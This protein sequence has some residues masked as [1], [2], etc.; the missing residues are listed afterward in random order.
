MKPI[1]LAR[2]LLTHPC[3]TLALR[4]YIGGLFIYASMYKINYTGEFAET[5]ANYQVVPY[6]GVNALA[7]VM[8]WLE[9]ISG[10]LL[11][12]GIRTKA[13]AAIISG[14]LTLFTF[15]VVV[16][17]ARDIPI[18]CGCFHSLEDP[19]SWKTAVRDLCWLAMALHIYRY[20]QTFQLE[21][22][23]LLSIKEMP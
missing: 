23:F 2:A 15:L 3:T 16:T 20:D 21:R 7:I 1:D 18:G 17:L 10:L 9:L 4:L 6:W 8:P 19:M 5:I 13:A 12:A 22:K 11:V 14:L